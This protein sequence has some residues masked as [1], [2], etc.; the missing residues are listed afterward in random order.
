[1]KKIN[2][3]TVLC[4]LT[5]LLALGLVAKSI[6]SSQEIAELELKI[7]ESRSYA[8]AATDYCEKMCNPSGQNEGEL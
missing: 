8:D 5:L 7:T 3:V 1:M 6:T 2:A 4:F